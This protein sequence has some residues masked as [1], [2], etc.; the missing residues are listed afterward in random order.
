MKI[1]EKYNF[2]IG[3]IIIALV[4]I[5]LSKVFFLAISIINTI[6]MKQSGTTTQLI[7]T[8]PIMIFILFPAFFIL[9]AIILFFCLKLLFKENPLKQILIAYS[10]TIIFYT[11]F[12]EFWGQVGSYNILYSLMQILVYVSFS[13]GIRMIY[14]KYYVK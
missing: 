14:Y 9:A 6:L 8:Y 3:I 1:L 11:L 4:G 12:R 2:Y 13:F 5:L 10:V 7:V